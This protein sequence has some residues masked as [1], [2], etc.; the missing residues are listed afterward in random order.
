MTY[1]FHNKLN[2]HPSSMAMVFQTAGS[3]ATQIIND[4]LAEVEKMKADLPEGLAFEIPMNNNEF[5]Y[6][7]IHNVIRTLI[8]AFVLVFFV[9]YIFLQDIRS[10]IIPPSPSPWP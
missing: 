7:S 10:T 9:V 4:V 2:G 8:E 6:A 5:L 3:N 1:G